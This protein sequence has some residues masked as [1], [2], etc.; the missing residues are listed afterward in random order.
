MNL[1]NGRKLCNLR[2]D[3]KMME[4]KCPIRFHSK[5]VFLSARHNFEPQSKHE[6]FYSGAKWSPSGED[7]LCTSQPNAVHLLGASEEI[8]DKNR[9]YVQD[10][11]EDGSVSSIIRPVA[12]KCVGE[13]IYDTA[14]YPFQNLNDPVTCC[15]VTTSKDQP[16]HLIDQHSFTSRCSYRCYDH[17]DE[18]ESASCLAFNSQGDK[19][20]AGSKSMVRCFDISRPG[21]D[22]Y[23]LP[24]TLTRRDYRG[25]RGIVSCLTFN[26][27]RSGAYAVGMYSRHVI[28]ADEC[29]PLAQAQLE[30]RDLPFGVTCLKWSPDGHKLW[31]GGRGNPDVLCWDIR[32]TKREVGKVQRSLNSNQRMTFDLDPWGAYLATGNQEGHLLMYDTQTFQEILVERFDGEEEGLCAKGGHDCL[33]C[34][35]FHPYAALLA[36]TT[37]Q[38]RFDVGSDSDDDNEDGSGRVEELRKRGKR[39]K[40]NPSAALIMQMQR[41]AQRLER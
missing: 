18:I 23:E 9:Y 7:L 35:S 30:I 33:N 21:R 41:N 17:M 40:F 8:I 1:P 13:A 19:L 29:S 34:V 24:T 11:V 4:N 3:L 22:F 28:I 27:D 15:F 39:A 20:Y 32:H 37:G 12:S 2:Y 31:V 6:E 26:P 14:W 5:G 10:E 36:C 38:R 25:L 16:I